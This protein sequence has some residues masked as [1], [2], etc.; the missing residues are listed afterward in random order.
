MAQVEWKKCKHTTQQE[1]DRTFPK[2]KIEGLRK[3]RKKGPRESKHENINSRLKLT[4]KNHNEDCTS[5]GRKKKKAYNEG[6]EQDRT[7]PESKIGAT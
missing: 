2:S 4:E 3:G 6:R 5:P 7:F 1:Q